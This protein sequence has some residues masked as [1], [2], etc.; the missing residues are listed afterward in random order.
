MPIKL[1]KEEKIALI[2]K[3][4]DEIKNNAASG[5]IAVSVT[6][7]AYSVFNQCYLANQHA[8]PGVFGGFQQWLK[9][10]R[11]V[12]KGEHGYAISY[13]MKK[14]F[15][16]GEGNNIIDDENP[17]FAS[18]TVFHEEQTEP[19]EEFE[20]LQIGIKSLKLTA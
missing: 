15:K 1:S 14:K 16:D 17:F 9:L 2:K 13:P 4:S 20:D 19:I 5:I 10:G 18:V 11:K 8:T 3:T 12:K 7:A 6:G